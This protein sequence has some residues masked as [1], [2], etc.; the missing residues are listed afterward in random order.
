MGF[1]FKLIS[2]EAI[3]RALYPLIDSVSGFDVRDKVSSR[4]DV[5]IETGEGLREL[6]EVFFAA[7]EAAADG[8][9]TNEEI[10]HIIL[11]SKDLPSA[12]DAIK[13]AW[14]DDEAEDIQEP[15][16]EYED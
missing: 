15:S 10:E 13:A 8:I 14:G 3:Q 6:S 12:L 11:Q 2:L 4:A 5:F 9:L 1:P 16:E 7:G